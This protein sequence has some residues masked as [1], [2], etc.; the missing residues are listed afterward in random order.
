MAR[1]H[2]PV[3]RSPGR[4][5]DPRPGFTLLEVLVALTVLSMMTTAL[6]SSF[7]LGV[8]S[9]DAGIRESTAAEEIRV[10]KQFLGHYL[11]AAVPVAVEEDDGW[12]NHFE[13]TP[14]NVRFLAEMP[15]HLG[16]GGLYEVRFGMLG[17]ADSGRLVVERRLFHPKLSARPGPGA[18]DRSI[19]AHDL[20]NVT[21]DYYGRR[22]GDE[23]AGWHPGWQE[24]VELPDLVRLRIRTASSAHW[25]V[26]VIPLKNRVPRVAP[27]TPGGA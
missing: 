4:R 25:P 20:Q 16:F 9:W 7:R 27:S 21:I 13:G 17:D 18:L 19:I 12:R 24:P 15:S 23:S 10:V 2:P 11:S 6:Y 26:L 14:E 5:T 3:A 1:P 22:H 8:K